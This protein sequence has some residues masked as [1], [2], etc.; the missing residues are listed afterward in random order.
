MKIALAQ[1]NPTIG[2]FEGNVRLI[3][4]A[5]RRAQ[6]RGADLCLTPE[7]GIC[8]YPAHDL[9]QRRRFVDQNLEAL[10][11]VVQEAPNIGLVVGFAERSDSRWGKGLFNSAALVF[12]GRILSIHRKSLLPTYDV[13]DESRYFDPAPSVQVAEFQ[14]IKLGIAICEDLWNDPEFWE[15][16]LYDRDP[17]GELVAAGAELILSIAASPFT[18][19]KRRLRREML[20]AAA[21]HHRTPILF[22]NMVGGNDE[23]VFDGASMAVSSDGSIVAA[24][25]E[26]E[27]D[28]V[29]VDTKALTAGSTPLRL[30]D[31]SD[32][33]AGLNA[34]V[35]G[36]RDYSR[37]CGFK[38]AILG[39][40]GGVDSALT[41]VIGARALGADRV[42]GILM[43][44]QYSSPGSIADAEALAKNL[45]IKHRIISI[46]RIFASYRND[47]TDSFTGLAPDVTEENL[48]ARIRGNLL[49]ALSNKFGHL[50]LSTGNKS[51]LATGY[52]TLYGDMAGGLAVLADVPKTLVYQMCAVINREREIIPQA[53]IDKAPSAELKSNQKDQDTLPPYDLLDAII[54]RHVVGELDAAAIVAQGFAASTVDRVLS[55]VRNSEYK[56]RQAPPGLKLSTKSFGYGRR[57]PLAHRWRP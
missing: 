54:E 8:G 10:D 2:D 37:K 3:L 28:L 52:C 33:E 27:E 57:I 55:L 22:C 51:E 26:F 31:G 46:D 21:L 49:M 1:I 18:I 19:A 12:Q 43:P 17:A 7:Q 32:A 25:R 14:G 30:D 38:S 42:E 20:K 15:R 41:A 35:L 48:Q 24:A 11:R 50:V 5:A 23:L 29:M 47:L 34:L 6:E 56:R 4:D 53:I 45:G 44:S 13:F 9:L 16:R 39:L 40:S 36:T